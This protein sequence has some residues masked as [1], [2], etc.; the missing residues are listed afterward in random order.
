MNQGILVIGHGSR[1]QE[2][3]QTFKSIIDKLKARGYKDVEGAHME[4]AEPNIRKAISKLA[5]K[6]VDTILVVPLFIYSGI[7]IQEDI[8]QILKEVNQDYPHITIRMGKAL[9]DDDLLIGLL[10]KRIQEIL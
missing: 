1:A 4:L 3:Q 6:G 10:E 9:E 2:A 5:E 8:P 7:H